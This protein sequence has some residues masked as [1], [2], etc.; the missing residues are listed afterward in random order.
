MICAGILFKGEKWQQ[1]ADS[2]WF[3]GIFSALGAALHGVLGFPADSGRR[4]SFL[5]F[6]HYSD[7][8]DYLR[9]GL[10]RRRN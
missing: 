9:H 10:F 5:E 6:S 8:L 7:S 3:N 1:M 4:Y 2:N